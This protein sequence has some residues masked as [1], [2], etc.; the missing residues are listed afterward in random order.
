MNMEL[1]PLEL[2]MVT[3]TSSLIASLFTTMKPLVSAPF[4]S[5]LSIFGK[6]LGQKF[7]F[8]LFRMHEPL[9]S[10]LPSR[11]TSLLGAHESQSKKEKESGPGW[12]DSALSLLHHPSSVSV[13]APLE[14]QLPLFMGSINGLF[15]RPF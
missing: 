12:V 14:L 4:S 1:T 6:C 11:T 13:P 9:G 10:F 15:K 2:T 7:A 3:V 8:F 5:S